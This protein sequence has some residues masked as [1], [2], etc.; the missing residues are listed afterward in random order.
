MSEYIDAVLALVERCAETDLIATVDEAR[1]VAQSIASEHALTPHQTRE[2]LALAVDYARTAGPRFDEEEARALEGLLIESLSEMRSRSKTATVSNR[3]LPAQ[4]R[5]PR[6]ATRE[7][8]GGRQVKRHRIL[9]VAANACEIDPVAFAEEYA[10]IHTQLRA[11]RHGGDF[12]MVPVLDPTADALVRHMVALDPVVI[13][14]AGRGA[15]DATVVFE[16]VS[17]RPVS[18][19]AAA[20]AGLITDAAPKARLVVLQD[21]T[22][23]EQG[24]RLRAV[25]DCVVSL[26]GDM[27]DRDARAFVGELYRGL[28]AALSV[29][30]A[31]V[32]GMNVLAGLRPDSARPRCLT[33][34]SVDAGQVCFGPSRAT[35][36]PRPRGSDVR[37]VV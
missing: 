24:N 7:A 12:E 29:A 5:I 4:W 6:R 2:L 27:A 14:I 28:G 11:S 26:D 23:H 1:L 25:I 16:D 31:T 19:S 34:E 8:Y 13:H 37:S 20:L 30:E 33:K 32:L 35:P 10:M 3:L 9:F 21:D 36:R 18:M 22:H 15:S 17:R